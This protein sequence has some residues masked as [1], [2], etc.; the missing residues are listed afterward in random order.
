MKKPQR[1][2]GSSGAIRD[3]EI[4]T[5]G[6]RGLARSQEG[7]YRGIF[8]EVG[9]ASEVWDKAQKRLSLKISSSFSLL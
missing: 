2:R 1:M 9:M 5:G 7:E 6:R 8:T 3:M 4:S